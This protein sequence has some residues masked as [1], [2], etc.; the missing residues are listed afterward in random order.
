MKKKRFK[1]QFLKG[2]LEKKLIIMKAIL[3]LT[4]VLGIQIKASVYSQATM[5]SL[6]IKD[7]PIREVLNRLEESSKFKFFYNED[8]INVD[9]QVSLKAS[10]KRIGEILT[11]IE[12]DLKDYQLTVVHPN[13]HISTPWA[14]GQISPKMPKESLLEIIKQPIEHWNENII[15]DFEQPVFKEY[16]NP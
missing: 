5:L 6:D 9:K 10:D 2:K 16:P 7:V 13:I 11:E 3:L 12:L 4:I 1:F 14:F 15:N 8:F